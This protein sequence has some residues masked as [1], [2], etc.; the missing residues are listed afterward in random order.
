[1]K[2]LDADAADDQDLSG[3]STLAAAEEGRLSST[4]VVDKNHDND[5]QPMFDFIFLDYEM[6]NPNGPGAAKQMRHLGCRSYILGVRGNV[7][8]ED[9]RRFEDSGADGVLAKPVKLLVLKEWWRTYDV[10]VRSSL[11]GSASA[12]HA[13]ARHRHNHDTTHHLPQPAV[14]A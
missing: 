2:F 3:A 12:K 1:M 4:V 14:A 8:Q 11:P 10:G 7:L 9:V 6:P 13:T 5:D